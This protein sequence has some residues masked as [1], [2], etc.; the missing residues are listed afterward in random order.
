MKRA[1]VGLLA[2]ASLLATL[3]APTLLAQV[4]WR[5]TGVPAAP[6][7][8][9]ITLS[10]MPAAD[11][12]TPYTTQTVTATGGIGGYSCAVTAGT[13][14][15][16]I[17]ETSEC[18]Y[19]GTPTTP[20]TYVFTV[21]V[22]DTFGGAGHT[23]DQ[24]YT[25]LINSAVVPP[26]PGDFYY[27]DDE[28]W[29]TSVNGLGPVEMRRS[30]GTAFPDG[31]TE[32]IAGGVTFTH[33]FGVF[34]TSEICYAISTSA[35][36]F[37]A[38]VGVDD[39]VGASGS[40]R[41][42]LEA[43]NGTEIYR[44]AALT[45]ASA[46][47]DIDQAISSKS[48]ICL[49]VEDNGNGSTNDMAVWG[50]PRILGVLAGPNLCDVAGTTTV[51]PGSSIAAALTT[52]GSSGR[53]CLENGVHRLSTGL[54]Q[55]SLVP[56]TSQTIIG[57]SL[58]AIVK[59]S[60]VLSS[61]TVSGSNYY[62]SGQTQAGST[63]L[64]G[65]HYYCTWPAIGLPATAP[66]CDYPEDLWI[67]GVRLFHEGTLAACVNGSWFFDYAADRIYVCGQNPNL[68]TVET[69]VQ[70]QLTSGSASGVR[71]ARFT[72]EY[73]ASPIQ[74]YTVYG[75]SDWRL[76]GLE[77]R[78]THGAC[79]NTQS[80][81]IVR[82]NYAH[83]N[84][85]YAIAGTAAGAL[86]EDNQFSYNG[87][88][89]VSEYWGVGGSKWADSAD[90][91]V[92]NNFSHHNYGPGLWTDINNRRFIYEYN[93]VEDNTR[94]GIFHEISFTA[95]IRYNVGRRNGSRLS[96]DGG[97]SP[98]NTKPNCSAWIQNGCIEILDSQSVDVHHNTCFNNIFSFGIT[99][100]EDARGQASDCTGDQ[101]TGHWCLN[102][103]T[104][105]DNWIGSNLS[106]QTW[107]G[108]T[109]KRYGETG[110]GDEAGTDALGEVTYTNNAYCFPNDGINY[111]VL[112]SNGGHTLL[113][114]AGWKAIQ[115][116]SVTTTRSNSC[117]EP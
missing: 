13:L 94:A 74:R 9:V 22:A 110:Y 100:L 39:A 77:C 104:I 111:F 35:T 7:A 33:G 2:C 53:V 72:Y 114:D 31:P 43:P 24:Q 64:N 98:P 60:V 16:G 42:V 96:F 115:D 27:L 12:D 93:T 102:A 47:V 117:T 6:A 92:R 109:S 69:S 79:L 58:S 87:W 103:I 11:E 28:Y 63:N 107:L 84:G 46:N 20:G 5:A 4:R 76:E 116:T 36:S 18:V 15:T 3:G 30:N 61:W 113:S 10:S 101:T 55:A 88:S 106:G 105:H 34:A 78:Q 38:T 65:S 85:Q 59:G 37:R 29:K 82:N 89:G 23:A 44:S 75:G 14:P 48:E 67:D 112:K 50:N 86:V 32:L 54:S 68:H 21:T 41:F 8:V 90:V 25:I 97:C 70:A 52:A 51:N 19:G 57:R 26:S 91:T 45:G 66:R 108:D 81:W 99:A 49:R 80:G 1:L 56:L 40:V 62:A 73:F 71:L 83:H 95:I 17:T